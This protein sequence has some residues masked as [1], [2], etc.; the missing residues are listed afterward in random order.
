M[1][2]TALDIPDVRL[3]QPRIFG[4]ERGFFYECYS[5]SG[6]AECGIPEVFVQ[7]NHSLSAAGVLRGLHYQM[8]PCAQAKLVRVIRGKIFDVAVDLRKSSPTFGRYVSVTMTAEDKSVLYVPVGF[9]HGFLALEG[10]TEV[11]YKVSREYS[12]EH[13]RG[14]IWSDASVG[15]PWPRLE[16]PYNLSKKD[17]LYPNLNDAYCFP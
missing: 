14:L 3:I 9:A 7:D 13:E 12:P 2:V 16:V 11:L 15:I 10:P 17:K 6:F 1:K 5:Q 4:D 8:P